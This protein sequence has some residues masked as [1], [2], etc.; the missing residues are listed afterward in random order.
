MERTM[1]ALFIGI[2]LFFFLLSLGLVKLCEKL[3]EA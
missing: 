3:Q 1:D 2:T